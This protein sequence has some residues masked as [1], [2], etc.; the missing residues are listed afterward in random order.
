[1]K[2]LLIIIAVLS[3]CSS[4][5]AGDCSRGSCN[6]PVRKAVSGVVDTAKN[7]VSVPVRVTKNTFSNIRSRR[8]ARQAR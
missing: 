7:I 4:V 8:S 2:N 5:F 1:M 3:M 6:R